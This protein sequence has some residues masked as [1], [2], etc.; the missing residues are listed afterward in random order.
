MADDDNNAPET[1]TR[2]EVSELIDSAVADAI[3]KAGRT[4]DE[5]KIR[6]IIREESA[7]AVKDALGDLV[8]G[9]AAAP[10]SD[11]KPRSAFER[12]MLGGD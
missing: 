6:A 7:A 11:A 5:K 12:F 1:F 8:P 9:K 2:E 10:A 3:G 4:D